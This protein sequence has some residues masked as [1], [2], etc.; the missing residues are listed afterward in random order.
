MSAQLAPM[1]AQQP[2]LSNPSMTPPPMSM[3]EPQSDAV[4]DRR[5]HEWRLIAEASQHCEE[6]ALHT[7]RQDR[8]HREQHFASEAERRLAECKAEIA[9]LEAARVRM[10]AALEKECNQVKNETI[11][12]VQGIQAEVDQMK[13]DQD[14]VNQELQEAQEQ[15]TAGDRVGREEM[16]QAESLLRAAS[17]RCTNAEQTLHKEEA[18]L[19]EIRREA[20]EQP[21]GRLA[22]ARVKEVAVEM[23]AKTHEVELQLKDVH[24]AIAVTEKKAK[25][26]EL[27]ASLK[28]E[29]LERKWSLVEAANE[30]LASQLGAVQDEVAEIRERALTTE[31]EARVTAEEI[32]EVQREASPVCLDFGA[33]VREEEDAAR[34]MGCRH[35]EVEREKAAIL[36]VSAQ[37]E[38]AIESLEA[39]NA[40]QRQEL[41]ELKQNSQAVMQANVEV[42]L[43]LANCKAEVSTVGNRS[44]DFVARVKASRHSQ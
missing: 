12:I 24:H 23:G 8:L 9:E 14:K 35:K 32:P 18:I 20:E 4:A 15:K 1:L 27:E 34:A 10:G 40:E 41:L 29:A 16:D 5:A 31:A 3:A 13:R 7:I 6:A 42:G 25:A 11:A 38:E 26:E 37:M 39:R 36:Q 28:E 22:D 2:P 19:G 17:D 43:E 33:R 21:P 30:T 44:L